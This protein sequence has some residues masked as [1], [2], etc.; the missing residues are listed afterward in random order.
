MLT[1][2]GSPIKH[3]RDILDLQD[4]V[5]LPKEVTVIHCRGHHKGEDKIANGNKATDEAVKRA[6]MQEYIAA[7]LLCE[8]TLLPPERPHYLTE[9]HKQ[10]SHQ[11][12]QLDHRG[13]SVS[14]RGKLWL[15][16]ALQKKILKT[17]HQLFPLSLDNILVLLNKTF[18]G[19]KLRDTAQQVVQGCETCQKISQ[20]IKDS[21]CQQ[22]Y[23]THMPRG[24]KSKLRLVLVHAFTGWVEAFPCS[25]ECAREVVRVVITEIIPLFGLPKS[26]QSDNGPAFNA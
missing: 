10:A 25:T 20:I 13:C 5:L 3:A 7:P 21:R 22:L 16:E 19:S 8:R 24:P 2:T 1:T 6:A 26:L 4:S 23:F 18:G 12:Y 17:L 14:P 9:E 15:P 11:G